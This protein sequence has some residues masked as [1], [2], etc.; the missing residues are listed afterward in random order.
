MIAGPTPQ[1]RQDQLIGR[2]G[3]KKPSSINRSRAAHARTGDGPRPAIAKWRYASQF[4]DLPH[5]SGVIGSY[6][7]ARARLQM[8]N[9]VVQRRRHSALGFLY[10]ACKGRQVFCGVRQSIPSSSIDSC[11]GLR[12]T[13]PSLAAGQTNRPVPVVWRTGKRPG[14]PTI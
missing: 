9:R 6:A 2:A 12:L 13:L 4:N 11:E 10:P 7:Y 5:Y 1:A 3:W 8:I 14:R